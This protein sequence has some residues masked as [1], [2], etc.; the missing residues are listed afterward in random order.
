MEP[1]AP[2]RPLKHSTVNIS[3]S[4]FTNVAGDSYTYNGGIPI[5][6]PQTGNQLRSHYSKICWALIVDSRHS[7]ANDLSLR[8]NGCHL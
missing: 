2:K 4:S 3:H 5:H 7:L 1:T 6:Q 8:F